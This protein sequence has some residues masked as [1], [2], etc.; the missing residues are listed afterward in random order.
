MDNDPVQGKEYNTLTLKCKIVEFPDTCPLIHLQPA[1]C[2]RCLDLNK[3]VAALVGDAEFE[4]GDVLEG[5]YDRRIAEEYLCAWPGETCKEKP[6]SERKA[7]QS[8]ERLNGH[9]NVRRKSVGADSA[10]AD[11]C[12]RLDAEEKCLAETF[13][14][15]SSLN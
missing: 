13:R 4:R 2:H 9:Q 14:K 3:L 10:V 15:S 1:E 12:Q 5:C 6:G 8:R 7:Q 11:R